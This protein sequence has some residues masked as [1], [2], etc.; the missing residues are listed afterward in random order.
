[1]SQRGWWGL[2]PSLDALCQGPNTPGQMIDGMGQN[3]D[4]VIE[5]VASGNRCHLALDLGER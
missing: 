5:L 4:V 3:S 1:M 2:S